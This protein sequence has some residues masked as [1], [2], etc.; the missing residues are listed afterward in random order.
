L[1]KLKNK[2][3]QIGIRSK[4]EKGKEERDAVAIEIS[5]WLPTRK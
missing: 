2:L 4:I 3:I 5:N 1:N